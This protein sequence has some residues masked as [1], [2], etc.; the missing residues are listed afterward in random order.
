MTDDA[1]PSNLY[2]GTHFS[3]NRFEFNNV[4]NPEIG[5]FLAVDNFVLNPYSTQDYNRYTYAN[6]NPLMYTDPD[7][8][9]VVAAIVI[10]TVIMGY[11]GY[12]IG[13]SHGATGWELAAYTLGGAVIGAVSGGVGGMISASG[14]IMANTMGTV[15]SSYIA[16]VG[17]AALGGRGANPSVNFGFGSYTFGEGINTIGSDGNKWYQNLGYVF[18]GMGNLQD[19]VVAGSPG[20][21]EYQYEYN[22]DEKIGSRVGHGNIREISPDPKKNNPVKISVANS[23]SVVT[24]HTGFRGVLEYAWKAN[25]RK[26]TGGPEHWLDVPET[27]KRIPLILNSKIVDKMTSNLANNRSLIGIDRMRFGINYGCVSHSARALWYSGVPTIPIINF[28]GPSVLYGQLFIRQMGIYSS[29]YL[30]QLK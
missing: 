24:K 3:E 9:A 8:E 26:Y 6:N 30:T 7:G 12:K 16:S 21:Y 5:R 17:F 4:V 22:P 19:L 29:P 15:F 27:G 2:F 13:Q 20:K 28:L 1:L 11:N 14:A 25:F 18:G 23:R 10:G